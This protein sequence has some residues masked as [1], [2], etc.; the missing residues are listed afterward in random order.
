MIFNYRY[1]SFIA[2][3]SQKSDTKF[4]EIIFSFLII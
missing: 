3:K 4:N 1:Y 2:N